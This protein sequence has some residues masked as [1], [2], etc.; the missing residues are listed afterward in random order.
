MKKL[1]VFQKASNAIRK[2]KWSWLTHFLGIVESQILIPAALAIG[3]AGK[4]YIVSMILQEAKK[5][6]AGQEKLKNVYDTCRKKFSIEEISN[7]FLAAFIQN[8]VSALK[9]E[10]LLD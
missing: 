9:V 5:D 10:N 4:N 1:S 6:I 3:E 7:D 8:T 2:W